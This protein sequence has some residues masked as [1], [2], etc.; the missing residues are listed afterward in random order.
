M[1]HQVQFYGH[2]IGW[3]GLHRE[4]GVIIDWCPRK[5]CIYIAY[6]DAIEKIPKFEQAMR[7]TLNLIRYLPYEP[8]ITLLAPKNV[9]KLYSVGLGLSICLLLQLASIRAHLIKIPNAREKPLQSYHT[10][11]RLSSTC[12]STILFHNLLPRLAG[13][14]EADALPF[15][16]CSSSNIH[17]SAQCRK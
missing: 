1:L 12:F 8:A 14:I 6:I 16:L 9:H 15:H 5:F 11:K 10:L 17:T 4:Q 2:E 3:V 7:M 13:S